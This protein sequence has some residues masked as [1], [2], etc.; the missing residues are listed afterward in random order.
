[1]SNDDLGTLT[2]QT[3]R[4]NREDAKSAKKDA[5]EEKET[6]ISQIQHEAGCHDLVHQV[7]E[8]WQ[9]T[10][11]IDCLPT[12]VSE[13]RLEYKSWHPSGQSYSLSSSSRPA[14][15]FRDGVQKGAC[16]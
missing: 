12:Q 2:A 7:V 1:M 6:R 14:F 13:P 11:R 16:P 9:I 8:R 5:K 15:A 10:S 4:L 3:L